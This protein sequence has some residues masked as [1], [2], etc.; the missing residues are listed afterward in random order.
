MN[1]AVGEFIMNST[2][3]ARS[4]TAKKIVSPF[5]IA[6]ILIV[7]FTILVVAANTL[8]PRSPSTAQPQS[9]LTTA[10][11][12]DPLA[13]IRLVSS[14][15]NDRALV[16]QYSA[17]WGRTFSE[18][19]S[20][21]QN[22]A[23]VQWLDIQKT[24]V[25]TDGKDIVFK[26]VF[27]PAELLPTEKPIIIT[28]GV[29]ANRIKIIQQIHGITILIDVNGDKIPDYELVRGYRFS[30]DILPA[31]EET[32]LFLRKMPN[33][34]RI[35]EG[36]SFQSN[37]GKEGNE[38]IIRVERASIGSPREFNWYLETAFLMQLGGTVLGTPFFGYEIY[39]LIPDQIRDYDPFSGTPQN[40]NRWQG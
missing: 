9:K 13:D 31:K 38:I 11:A 17:I 35:S 6:I 15:C 20:S 39:D 30:S 36:L 32:E 2:D 34:Q 10:V 24:T 33:G 40:W 18:L 26:I 16:D 8:G 21:P 27:K 22:S 12:N 5:K 1:S 3:I 29:L 23:N 25:S 19:C 4:A 37:P 28:D 14:Y 7:L